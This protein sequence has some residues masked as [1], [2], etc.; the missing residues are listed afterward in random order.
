MERSD[1][2]YFVNRKAREIWSRTIWSRRFVKGLYSEELEAVVRDG[3]PEIFWCETEDKL[4]RVSDEDA[5]QFWAT[6]LVGHVQPYDTEKDVT[7]VE[8][9]YFYTAELWKA[10]FGQSVLLLQLHH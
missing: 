9:G 10:R 2:Q 6:K 7:E 3:D 8:G 1:E 4:T 5:A